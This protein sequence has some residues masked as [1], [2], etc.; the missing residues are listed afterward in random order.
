MN[1]SEEDHL[2]NKVVERLAA[3][4]GQSLGEVAAI[5][6]QRRR[7]DLSGQV[8]TALQRE[9]P[10]ALADYLY[11]EILSGHLALKYL[12]FEGW[13]SL[14]VMEQAPCL[15]TIRI[16]PELQQEMGLEHSYCR[17]ALPYVIFVATINRNGCDALQCY[18]RKSPWRSLTDELFVAPLPNIHSESNKVCLGTFD[19]Y[20][21]T[22]AELALSLVNYFWQA[23][24]NTD[25]P[26]N[27]QRCAEHDPS[28]QLDRWAAATA[29][30]PHRFRRKLKLLPTNQTVEGILEEARRSI[31][32]SAEWISELAIRCAQQS[33]KR[34]NEAGP[35]WHQ[36]V[37]TLLR[38]PEAREIIAEAVRAAVN[39]TEEELDDQE[40]N[41]EPHRGWRGW[42]PRR[43]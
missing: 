2:V 43:S 5:D 36:V 40:E 37:S 41:S 27:R 19:D 7:S 22:D 38:E 12:C 23:V 21:G 42:R 29:T 25:L 31:Q 26:D 28:I 39:T 13:G 14:F 8:A 15:K 9:L 33:F 24:F 30:D 17:L 35:D 18:F 10:D 1:K 20:S 4:L 6:A 11:L 32:Q 34:V 3:L 16:S